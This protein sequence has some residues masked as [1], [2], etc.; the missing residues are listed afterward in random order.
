[1]VQNK[2]DIIFNLIV[3]H[4]YYTVQLAEEAGPWVSINERVDPSVTSY[5]ATGLKPYTS[6]RFR[7][8]ATNDIGPS[9]WSIDSAQVRTLPA[10]R[11]R[12]KMSGTIIKIL[13]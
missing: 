9:G 1:M 5:T 3:R 2:I 11:L 8:Q 10:G 12:L 7:M 6:Y 13:F 4:R